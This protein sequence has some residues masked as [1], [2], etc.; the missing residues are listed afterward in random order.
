MRFVD[1]ALFLGWKRIKLRV[2]SFELV[3]TE[4]ET[5]HN[6]QSKA[7]LLIP[8]FRGLWKLVLF[9]FFWT[10]ARLRCARA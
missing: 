3:E 2:F 8:S 7:Q 6:S 1:V 5:Q 4:H 9:S 10:T